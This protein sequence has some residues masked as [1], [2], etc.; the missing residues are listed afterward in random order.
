MSIATNRRGSRGFSAG[1]VLLPLPTTKEWGE[2]RGEGQRDKNVPPLPG[3]LLHQMGGRG[4]LVAAAPRYAVSPICD[5]QGRR[6]EE[7]IRSCRRAA[8]CNSAIRQ[9]TNLRYANQIPRR[10]GRGGL[11]P[12]E[13]YFR[14]RRL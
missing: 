7:R 1:R 10:T 3:P 5:R 11:R 14:S 13:G 8:E 9:I 2:E 12:R 4:S 6:E